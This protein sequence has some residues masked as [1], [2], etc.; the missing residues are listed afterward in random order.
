MCCFRGASR[1]PRA[2]DGTLYPTLLTLV[3]AGT[4]SGVSVAS[5]L[6][7][8]EVLASLLTLTS[9]PSVWKSR[10]LVLRHT[11]TQGGAACGVDPPLWQVLHPPLLG[12][13]S[14]SLATPSLFL[15]QFV[16][17]PFAGA[18]SRRPD[19]WPCNLGRLWVFLEPWS[20]LW[21]RAGALRLP[22]GWGLVSEVG[23]GTTD[24]LSLPSA[25]PRGQSPQSFPC[26]LAP[27][28]PTSPHHCLGLAG[29]PV[30]RADLGCR[31]GGT[32]PEKR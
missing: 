23:P 1:C 27:Q 21:P 13:P 10:Q 32:H 2:R 29:A 5:G 22:A 17:G 15:E 4:S 8:A 11:P 3:R 6:V 30:S 24:P 9:Q 25:G 28:T 16:C 26:I 18:A 31:T 7:A 12:Q 14:N 19:N 20:S